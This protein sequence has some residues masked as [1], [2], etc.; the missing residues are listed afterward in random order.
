MRQLVKEI[1]LDRDGDKSIQYLGVNNMDNNGFSITLKYIVSVNF[2]K[3]FDI[4]GAY[5]TKFLVRD[6]IL[7]WKHKDIFIQL[8]GQS[9]ANLLNNSKA[10][11]KQIKSNIRK[12]NHKNMKHNLMDLNSYFNRNNILYCLHSNGAPGL[13]RKCIIMR[14]LRFVKEKVNSPFDFDELEF[15]EK[16]LG[17]LTNAMDSNYRPSNQFNCGKEA[18]KVKE[19][20]AKSPMKKPLQKREN[21]NYQMGNSGLFKTEEQAE[22]NLKQS[23]KIKSKKISK[24]IFEGGS[25]SKKSDNKLMIE[26]APCTRSDQGAKFPNRSSTK[27]EA[28]FRVGGRILIHYVFKEDKKH[29]NKKTMEYFETF[30]SRFVR[31]L[32][33][34]KF[35]RIFY[36]HCSNKRG[37]D[38]LVIKDAFT[39]L[40]ALKSLEKF[41]KNSIQISKH[42]KR[43]QNHFIKKLPKKKKK[44]F[45]NLISEGEKQDS[46]EKS[47]ACMLDSLNKMFVED[48]RVFR[49]IRE[50]T[51]KLFPSS[52]FGPK[53]AGVILKY[54]RKMVTIKRF[55]SF[56]IQ[57]IIDDLD[58]F[59]LAF[60]KRKFNNFYSRQIRYEKVLLLRPVLKFIFEELVMNLLKFNF[61]ITEKHS[62]HNQLFYYPKAVW[63]LISS[64]GVFEL[65]MQNCSRLPKTRTSK[66]KLAP[67][68][69]G[70]LRFVPKRNSLRPL[71]SF[72]KK[73]LNKKTARMERISKYLQPV[74][75]VLRSVKKNLSGRALTSRNEGV[76][77]ARQLP[78]FRQVLEVPGAVEGQG[79][80]QVVRGHDGY[81]EVLRQCGH[82]AADQHDQHGELLRGAV[83]SAPVHQGHPQQA[84][85]LFRNQATTKRANRSSS[86]TR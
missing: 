68:P 58:L 77:R 21:A 16:R 4:L 48:S 6:C 13:F 5:C 24:K 54:M 17:E 7:I 1:F 2:Q 63:Y 43:K 41:K 50:I 67:I 3:L 61:Y 44:E 81:S 45:S 38:Y 66:E 53:N 35:D 75:I 79:Q 83:H 40:K 57:D 28:I 10:I 19:R 15:T 85:P 31:K 39:K 73:F 32:F 25:T 84:V 14:V 55:E 47:V 12:E 29:V 70:K 9:L 49:F 30:F 51:Q 18:A 23:L 22:K 74:K 37:F 33:S 80:A 82:Q 11:A 27:M 36:H 72:F 46:P 78:D 42:L 34:I 86:F 8:S 69:L 60:Y 59:N 71:M 56:C 20:L 64:I 52:F 76:Q 62:T 26:T 65:C